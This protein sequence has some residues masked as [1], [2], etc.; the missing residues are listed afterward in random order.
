MEVT[1]YADILFLVNFSLNWFSL[2]LTSKIIKLK[3]SALRLF[4][5]AAAG[6]LAGTATVV[7]SQTLSVALIEIAST[8]LMCAIAFK[9][10]G[11][12]GY[13]KI[14]TCL[15]ASGVTLGG[16]LTLIY[17]FFNRTGIELHAQNDLSSAVF[18]L[19]SFAVTVSAIIFERFIISS[20]SAKQGEVRIELGEKSLCLPFFSDSGN[21][22]LEPISGKPAIIIEKSMLEELLPKEFSDLNSLSS[23]AKTNRSLYKRMRLL[24]AKT[25]CGD[26]IMLGFIPDRITLITDT[27]T[28]EAD[29]IIAVEKNDKSSGMRKSAIVPACLI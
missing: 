7:F 22:L 10:Y 20:K 15:F 3:T 8:F 11:I 1:V 25:V 24:P 14:C 26:G 23:F 18:I 17:S 13:I 6:A 12:W 4:L 9:A 2:L 16:S 21:F 28:K 19:L 5:S 27:G 29:A